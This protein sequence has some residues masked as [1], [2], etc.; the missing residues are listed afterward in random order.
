MCVVCTEGGRI[1]GGEIWL[2]PEDRERLKQNIRRQRL[3]KND[4]LTPTL[5]DFLVRPASDRMAAELERVAESRATGGDEDID[6]WAARLA[7][8]L[9]AFSD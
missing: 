5:A 8:D 9:S 7:A 6:K 1:I 3:A 4:G 2:K